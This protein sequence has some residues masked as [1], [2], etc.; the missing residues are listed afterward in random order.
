MF[1]VKSPHNKHTRTH[2]YTHTQTDLNGSWPHFMPHLIAGWARIKIH[3][4]LHVCICLLVCMCTYILI[5]PKAKQ[6]SH[7]MAQLVGK[8]GVRGGEGGGG[9]GGEV[10]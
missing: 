6:M 2:A 5:N 1:T 9:S 3:F 7:K 10:A 4:I 8:L